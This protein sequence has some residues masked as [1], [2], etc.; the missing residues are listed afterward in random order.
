[1]NAPGIIDSGYS[2]DVSTIIFNSGK[3]PI[4]FKHG[5]KISQ[6]VLLKLADLEPHYVFDLDQG[7]ITN[8]VEFV[9]NESKHRGADGFGSTGV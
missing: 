7:P 9:K 8:A 6:L 2:G 1:M 5:D 3:Q 4:A